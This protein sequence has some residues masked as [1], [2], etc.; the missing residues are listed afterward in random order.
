MHRRPGGTFTL[1]ITVGRNGR[2][3]KA[4]DTT[5]RRA[6]IEGLASLPNHT[7]AKKRERKRR[8]QTADRQPAPHRP[9]QGPD[10][11]PGA[12]GCV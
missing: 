7:G 3:T 4:D 2:I 9:S 12:Q 8:E 5:V 6:V 10:P 1:A 11:G